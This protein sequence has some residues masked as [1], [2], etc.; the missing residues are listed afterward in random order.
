MTFKTVE[1]P[2]TGPSYQSRSKPLSSQRTINFYQQFSEQGKDQ[3]VLMPFPGLLQQGSF[4]TELADRGMTRMKEVLYQVKGTTLYKIDQFGTHT[5][6]GTISGSNRCIFANDGI[7]L[8]IVDGEKA[9]VYSSDTSGFKEITDSTISGA[10]SVTVIN[11]LF[12][13]TFDNISTTHFLNNTS[14]A[15]EYQGQIGAEVD[16]D[17]LVR[18]FVFEQTIW[19]FGTRTIEAWY[20]SGTGTPPI[21]RIEGQVFDVGCSAL[22]SIAKTDEFF[23]WL[24]DDNSIYRARAGSKERISTDAISNELSKID[25]TNAIGYTFTL[26]GQ[27]F[28]ALQLPNRPTFVIN[29]RLGVNGWFELSSGLDDGEYQATSVVS[30]YNGLWAA[31]KSSGKVYTLDLDTYTNDG[32]EIKRT[33][34]TNTLSGALFGARGSRIQMSKMEIDMETGLG[35]ISGQGENPRIMIEASYDGGNT[36]SAGSWPKVGRLGQH[37]LRVEWFSLKSF[38]DMMVRITITDPVSCAIYGSSINVR[39][40]GT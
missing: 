8:V 24:G 21:A 13:F 1:F 35:L 10:K 5:S 39:I 3:F 28:Y 32:E 12:I 27:N 34:V 11:S 19:R 18:D 22:Y 20:N 25:T 29:E 40:A 6:L 23:Y 7:N 16:P 17:E 33:R 30:V 2:I 26:Q 15:F 37:T 4:S 9:Y 14:K 38:Y 36:W 31:D